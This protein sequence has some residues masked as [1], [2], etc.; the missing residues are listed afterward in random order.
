M[1]HCIGEYGGRNAET[2][3]FSRMV[4]S[5]AFYGSCVANFELIAGRFTQS[6]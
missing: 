5:A 2:A 3:P 6:V 4:Q 1:I